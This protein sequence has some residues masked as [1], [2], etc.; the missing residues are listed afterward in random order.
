MSLCLSM[1]K[2]NNFC[3]IFIGQNG[4][5]KTL[6]IQALHIGFISLNNILKTRTM[7]KNKAEFS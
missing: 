6:I 3:V 2:T 4:I 5:Q 7:K 1:S